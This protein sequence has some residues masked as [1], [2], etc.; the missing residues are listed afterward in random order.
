MSVETF[1][2]ILRQL[3]SVEFVLLHGVGEPMMNPALFDIIAAAKR[4]NKR[5][6]FNT[7]GT[8]L[9]ER[10]V[11]RVVESGLD[12]LVVSIDGATE[13]TFGEIRRGAHLDQVVGNVR[14]LM[15]SKARAGNDRLLVFVNT[16]VSDKNIGEIP[17]IL[18]IVAGLGV[19]HLNLTGARRDLHLQKDEFR[20]DR[21]QYSRLADLRALARE[22]GLTLLFLPSPDHEPDKG[23]YWPWEGVYVTV[24]GWVTPCC[25]MPFAATHGLDNILEKEFGRIWNSRRYKDLRLSLKSDRPPEQCPTCPYRGREEWFKKLWHNAYV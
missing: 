23:C 20:P 16:V 18:R 14:M 17:D 19:K 1:N 3:P 24:E 10:N 12:S 8:L 22:L 21:E 11:R 5:V 15:D 4:M 6:G 13:K 25:C 7:N 9:N 2:R